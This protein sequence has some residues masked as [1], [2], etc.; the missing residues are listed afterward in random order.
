[1]I[2][3]ASSVIN[4]EEKLMKF[5]IDSDFDDGLLQALST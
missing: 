5:E 1:M 2:D 4:G 3:Y